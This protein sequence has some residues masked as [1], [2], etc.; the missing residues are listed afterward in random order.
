[1][2]TERNTGRN[3]SNAKLA[4]AKRIAALPLEEQRQHSSAVL[5][6][7]K[8]L[9]HNCTYDDLPEFYIDRPFQCVDCGREEIWK[10]V[11]QKWYYEKAKGD[12]HAKAI[13]CHCCR[14]ARSLKS[15]K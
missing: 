13:R 2:T 11:D 9:G 3:P 14:M 12:I 10:A 8:K 6:S 1:M 5:A 4:E 7:K 15:E